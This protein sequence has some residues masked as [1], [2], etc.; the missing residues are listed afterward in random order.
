ML[1][2]NTTLK[3]L[4]LSGLK[5]G[6]SGLLLLLRALRVNSTLEDLKL[7]CNNLTSSCVFSL[8]SVCRVNTSITSL[9]LSGNKVEDD[10]AMV[11]SEIL[12]QTSNFVTLN[13]SSK[14]KLFKITFPSLETRITEEGAFYLLKAIKFNVKLKKLPLDLNYLI[15]KETK[16]LLLQQLSFNNDPELSEF[17]KQD[18]Q[19]IVPLIWLIERQLWIAIEKEFP[20]E[21]PFS[22]PTPSI[23][24]KKI[25]PYCHQ[26]HIQQIRLTYTY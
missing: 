17:K 4:D 13:L 6:D 22:L 9:D 2:N 14:F 16:L 8:A 25:L 5:L 19:A 23:L 26:P 15:S 11:I 10:G 3:C 1:M 12:I 21:C 24:R 7:K 20:L 18:L